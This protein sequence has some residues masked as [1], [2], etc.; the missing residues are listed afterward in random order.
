VSPKYAQHARIS[1]YFVNNP[2][3]ENGLPNKDGGHC[4]G[5][6]LEGTCAVR[7][8][9]ASGEY[10]AIRKL[11]G[12]VQRVDCYQHLGNRIRCFPEARFWPTSELAIIREIMVA[13]V[14][15]SRQCITMKIVTFI[16][17]SN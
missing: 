15:R 5:F 6:S 4:P 10:N 17:T 1:L 12:S 11:E 7:F 2:T 9:R 3:A 16:H 14:Q 8:H 13:F